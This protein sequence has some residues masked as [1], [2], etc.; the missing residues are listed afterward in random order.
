MHYLLK[1]KEDKKAW[2]VE[3]ATI[4]YLTFLGKPFL[5]FVG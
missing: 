5:V 3:M 2:L 4:F 1:N